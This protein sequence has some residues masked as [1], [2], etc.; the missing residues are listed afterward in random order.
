MDALIVLLNR[1]QAFVVM[2]AVRGAGFAGVQGH[3]GANA[4]REG[5]G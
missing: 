2:T 4:P 1:R 3:A 5:G